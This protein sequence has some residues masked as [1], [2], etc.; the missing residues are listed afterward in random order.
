MKA[1]DGWSTHRLTVKLLRCRFDTIISLQKVFN[2]N[3]FKKYISSQELSVKEVSLF[4]A[5]QL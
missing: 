3:L 1:M 4:S 2:L 5:M